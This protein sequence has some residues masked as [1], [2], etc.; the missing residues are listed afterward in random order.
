MVIN[1]VY[2]LIIVGAWAAYKLGMRFGARRCAVVGC[3][4]FPDATWDLCTEHLAQIEAE[5]EADYAA[6]GTDR[7][8]GSR[9]A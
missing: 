9:D 3:T 5:I 8:D 4:A 7:E 1:G 6:V 2:I